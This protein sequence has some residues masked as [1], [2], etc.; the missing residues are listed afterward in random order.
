MEF[1]KIVN[2]NNKNLNYANGLHFLKANGIEI[3]C[4][5]FNKNYD[6]I[7]L[8][9]IGQ[10]V[11]RTE[12][13]FLKDG[14]KELYNGLIEI[15]KIK[16]PSIEN[17]RQELFVKYNN[18]TT[19]LTIDRK[20]MSDELFIK[21]LD[22]TSVN[23]HNQ[24]KQY[25]DFAI[26]V[27]NYEFLNF[28]IRLS[29]FGVIVSFGEDSIKFVNENQIDVALEDKKED[30]NLLQKKDVKF[31]IKTF[32]DNKHYI[33]PEYKSYKYEIE[34]NGSFV[35]NVKNDKVKIY[36][37]ELALILAFQELKA[38]NTETKEETLIDSFDYLIT[39]IEAYKEGERYFE[40]NF[41]VSPNTLYGENAQ[42]YIKDIHLNFFHIFH[43]GANEGWGFVKNNYPLILTHKVIKEF[44]YYSGIVDK[45]EAMVKKYPKQF[46]TFE[47][48]E[49]QNSTE[50][51]ET[52]LL[53]IDIAQLLEEKD[54]LKFQIERAKEKI[55]AQEKEILRH[56]QRAEDGLE[57]T[58]AF[59]QREL[60]KYISEKLNLE[61]ELSKLKIRIKAFGISENKMQTQEPQQ[62]NEIKIFKTDEVKIELHNHIFKSNAFEVF[63]SYHS[64]KELAENSKTDLSLLFQVLSNDN[65]FVETVELKHYIKWLNK[66][67]GYSL[68]E[69]KKTNITSKPNIVRTNDYKSIKDATLKQP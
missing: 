41:S 69:L 38:L 56:K 65:L 18:K 43:Y 45:V 68:T 19:E 15:E 2:H 49:H 42:Q 23:N 62:L 52:N 27:L 67:Y 44:G 22:N 25:Y 66:T 50:Q 47:I 17:I 48:C 60:P 5:D 29:R 63:E 28:K 55:I 59:E 24:N 53:N 35:V 33:I 14:L 16:T 46:Q 58:L 51:N 57:N 1:S 21:Y 34:N 7:L 40:E 8:N 54:E 6:E 37:P 26:Q 30:I 61:K 3:T 36:T 13:V 11:H 20:P 32:D 10:K 12:T 64:T 31:R 9:Y 39:Y 4:V